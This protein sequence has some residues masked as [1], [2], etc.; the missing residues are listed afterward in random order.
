HGA[1][2]RSLAKRTD[3]V[4][5]P[6]K[7]AGGGDALSRFRTYSDGLLSPCETARPCHPVIQTAIVLSA[8]PPPSFRK[9]DRLNLPILVSP[10]PTGPMSDIH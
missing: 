10:T 9:T 8:S 5:P 6:T 3:S 4:G 1:L 2:S 7:P